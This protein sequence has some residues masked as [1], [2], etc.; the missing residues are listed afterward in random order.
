MYIYMFR[1]IKSLTERKKH[2]RI[3]KIMHVKPPTNDI[4]L[5]C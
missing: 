1:K 2:I 4:V 5:D 3:W